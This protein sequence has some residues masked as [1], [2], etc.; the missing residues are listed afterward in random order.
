MGDGEEMDALIRRYIRSANFGANEWAVFERF[1]PG[2]V[3]CAE[4]SESHCRHFAEGR[5]L[6]RLP[7]ADAVCAQASSFGRGIA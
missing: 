2:V 4:G 6:V 3:V 7:K 1:G 5:V